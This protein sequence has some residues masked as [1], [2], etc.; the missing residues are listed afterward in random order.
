MRLYFRTAGPDERNGA[1]AA[2]V[3]IFHCESAGW[4][5]LAGTYARGSDGSGSY[6]E[7]PERDDLLPLRAGRALPRRGHAG[8]L[9]GRRGP[10]RRRD[11]PSPGR[12]RR[13]RPTRAS[14][15]GAATPPA[16]PDI[17]LN[18]A[19]IPSQAPGGA[20]GASYVY[21]DTY[22]LRPGATYFYWLEDVA[23]DGAATRHEPVGVTYAGP[24]AVTL[25]S[26]RAEPVTGLEVT[27]YA[28][29]TVVAALALAGLADAVRAAVRRRRDLDRRELGNGRGFTRMHADHHRCFVKSF[30][31]KSVEFDGPSCIRG[32]R[33]ASVSRI[34]H[35]LANLDRSSIHGHT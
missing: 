26:L 11:R 23:L 1:N 14:T 33:A 32:I 4:K 6:V 31:P 20:L 12:P 13:R 5:K 16:G 27:T 30:V 18:A 9:P 19:V 28:V 24:T 3:E 7:L 17:R 10:G 34:L 2:A 22:A 25:R 15:S 21:T 29:M 8:R 35:R